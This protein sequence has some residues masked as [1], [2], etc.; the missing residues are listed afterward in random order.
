MNMTY[1]ISRA[2]QELQAKHEQL[3]LRWYPRYHLAARAG[4]IN[5]PNGLVWFDGWYHAFYQHP[6]VL[7]QMGADALGPRAQ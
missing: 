4:W 5:D 2:E 7:H 6:S 1:S 3:N